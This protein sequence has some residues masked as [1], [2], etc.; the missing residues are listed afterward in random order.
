[1][2]IA[3][4][5]AL[6]AL[7]LAVYANIKLARDIRDRNSECNVDY[8]RIHDR[9]TRNYIE[10]EEKI[11]KLTSGLAKC[12]ASKT[13][14]SKPYDPTTKPKRRPRGPRKKPQAKK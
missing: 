3:N 1:M 9:I 5:M 10:H 14:V 12:E 13:K 6:T 4:I 7:A 2:I 11:G 8:Q